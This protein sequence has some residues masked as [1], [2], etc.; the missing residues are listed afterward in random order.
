MS[1][2]ARRLA[3]PV[4]ALALAGCFTI[5]YER[6]AAPEAGLPREQWHHGFVG[7][8]ID[9]SGPVDLDAICPD[10]Y[11]RVENEVTPPNW[12][13]QFL[14]GFG[15]LWLATALLFALLVAQ[16]A[17]RVGEEASPGRT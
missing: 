14:T 7:G 16:A 10:S 4:A 8:L 15:G 11:A 2:A 9:G 3:L 12:L 17:R 13:G 5:R 1:R 6:R